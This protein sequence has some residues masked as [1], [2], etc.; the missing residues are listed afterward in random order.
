M[1][2]VGVDLEPLRHTRR[3]GD[4][5]QYERLAGIPWYRRFLMVLLWLLLLALG[6]AAG[7]LLLANAGA[8]DVAQVLGLI[9]GAYGILGAASFVWFAVDLARRATLASF[10]WANGWAYADTLEHTRRPGSAFTRVLRGRERAVIVSS[11]PRLPFELGRHYSV[12]RSREE[13]A[14]RQW[15][16]SFI[17]LP[18]PTA[19]PNI[20]LR[21]RRRSVVPSLGFGRANAK[22]DLEGDFASRFTLLVPRGYE[23]DALYIF[24]P[25]LMHRVMELGGGAEIELSGDRLYVYL[26]HSTRFDRPA[27]MQ[28]ALVLAEEFHR[29]FA[30]RTTNYRDDRRGTLATGGGAV[31]LRGQKLAGNGV[32][33]IAV[34]AG[35]AMVL[36]SGAAVAFA[37]FGAPLFAHGIG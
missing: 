26:P 4:V 14:T 8:A 2:P 29:R 32:P 6:V 33:L 24:T 37:L 15:P 13:A 25:D 7:I 1:E 28:A 22:L 34:A 21:N 9:A 27:T 36:L 31:S 12:A 10:A 3:L 30:A 23:R 5:L 19:V 20:F 18:L 16:F 35:A 11:D 17:E